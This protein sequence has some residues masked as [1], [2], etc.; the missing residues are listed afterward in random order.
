MM[1]YEYM[2]QIPAQRL[3]PLQLNRWQK[4]S[5]GCSELVFFP[6]AQW[7]RR[8]PVTPLFKEFVWSNIPLHSKFT[9]MGYMFSYYAIGCAWALTALNYF[10]K[11]WNLPVDQYCG[12]NR[13]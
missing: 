6:F 5:F 10:V 9:V 12:F 7:F 8:G 4:Y 2:Y 1:R 3:T 13:A 11:G